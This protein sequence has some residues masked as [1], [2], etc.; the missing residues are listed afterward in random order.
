MGVKRTANS[1][2]E[3]GGKPFTLSTGPY[4]GRPI[5][6]GMRVCFNE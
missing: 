3:G 5:G 2:S 6:G 4:V 1:K